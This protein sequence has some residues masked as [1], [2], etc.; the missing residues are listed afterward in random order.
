[1]ANRR[2]FDAVQRRYVFRARELIGDIPFRSALE[3]ARANWDSEHPESAIGTPSRPGDPPFSEVTYLVYPPEVSLSL[4]ATPEVKQ[5]VV[6]WERLIEI[7]CETWWPPTR[8]PRP[9]T[10]GEHPAARFVSACLVWRLADVRA[11]F[12]EWLERRTFDEPRRIWFE[13][14]SILMATTRRDPFNT[15]ADPSFIGVAERLESLARQLEAAAAARITLTPEALRDMYDE[16]AREGREADRRAWDHAKQGPMRMVVQVLAGAERE[17][18]KAALESAV[19]FC[20]RERAKEA[21]AMAE[22]VRER[23]VREVAKSF[24]RSRTPVLRLRTEPRGAK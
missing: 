13:G 16:M 9:T 22:M 7:L 15:T 21:A 14:V 17:D 19:D 6:A 23:S 2:R 5:R 4:E 8:F 11:E 24:G 18:I 3:T 20:Q 12:E 10:M 1:V